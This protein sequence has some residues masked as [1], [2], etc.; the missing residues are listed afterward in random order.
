MAKEGF[1][2][3]WDF[4][5]AGSGYEG[6][7]EQKKGS[8]AKTLGSE[9]LSSSELPGLHGQVFNCK[10]CKLEAE[11]EEEAIKFAA[12]SYGQ[13][14]GGYAVKSSSGAFKKG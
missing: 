4:Q 10:F 12:E 11:S 5:P 3:A 6:F 13:K 1:F 8:T 2:V 9:E 7:P 14:S